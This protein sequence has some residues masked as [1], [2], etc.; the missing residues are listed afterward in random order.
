MIVSVCVPG[1]LLWEGDESAS[2]TVCVKVCACTGVCVYQEDARGWEV[3]LAA[4]G[5][6]HPLPSST[7]RDLQAHLVLK[8]DKERRA[9]RWGE[10]PGCWDAHCT[11]PP[12]PAPPRPHPP[13]PRRLPH[14]PSSRRRSLSSLPQRSRVRPLPSVP[15]HP[16]WI[17]CSYH[18]ILCHSGHFFGVFQGDPGAVGAPGKTGP[19][20]PAGPAGKPGPDGLRGLPGSVVSRDAEARLGWEGCGAGDTAPDLCGPLKSAGSAR[21]SR[22]HRPGWASRPCGE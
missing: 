10:P 3:S 5:R 22:G 16:P 4:H 14:A 1:G 17:R 21:P 8:G 9:P 2:V 6:L 13:A 7:C 20:G 12:C 11:A 15:P 18:T 19:V